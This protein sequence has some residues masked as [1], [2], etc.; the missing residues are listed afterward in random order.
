MAK[1]AKKSTGTVNL[2]PRATPKK[3]VRVSKILDE[4][5]TGPEVEWDGWEEWPVEKFMKERR[6]AFYYYN[7]FRTGKEMK[8][9]VLEWMKQAKYGKAEISAVRRSKDSNCNATLGIV[10][11]LLLRGMP[12]RH[13]EADAY[14]ETKPGLISIGNDEDFLRKHLDPLIEE[15]KQ[16]MKED[17]RVA[18]KTG[19]DIPIVSVKDRV[20][21]QCNT[22][23]EQVEDWLDSFIDNPRTFKVD[24]FNVKSHFEANNVTQAHARMIRE[25]YV[26]WMEEVGSIVNAKKKTDIDSQLREGYARYKD[27]E[28]KRIYAALS[29]IVGS[30]DLIIDVAKAN[31]KTRVK[32]APSKEKLVARVKY[33]ESDSKYNL[34][35]INP[36]EMIDAKEIW[37][38]NV[39]TRKLGRYIAAEDAQVMTVKGAYIAGFDEEKS[40]QRNLRRPEEMLAEFKAAGKV[41]L[42]KF[43]DDLKTVEIKLNGKLNKDT[44]ILKAIH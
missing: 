15:G 7:Y 10:A 32:K 37:V 35:S 9:R 12:A 38:F 44:V 4:R 21:E 20:R 23:L 2:R 39:K 22:I 34:A 29:E 40:I 27:A 18:A 41:K 26:A 17:K 42:R 33:C 28:L 19:D 6:A 31:R 1:K 5:Y 14:L 16:A 36:V 8:P 30:C 43:M 24:S 11:T 3:S 25:R 13:P